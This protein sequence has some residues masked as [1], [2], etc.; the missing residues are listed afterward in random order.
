LELNCGDSLYIETIFLAKKG[1]KT[2]RGLGKAGCKTG[3]GFPSIE[4]RFLRGKKGGLKGEEPLI[5][6]R[7]AFLEGGTGNL[8]GKGGR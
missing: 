2:G 7:R 1:G 6:E 3:G 5:G 4:E 8:R